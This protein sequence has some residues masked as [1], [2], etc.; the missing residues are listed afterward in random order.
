MPWR[1]PDEEDLNRGRKRFRSV[2]E[3]RTREPLVARFWGRK[4]ESG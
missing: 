4:L 1:K 3:A 2:F